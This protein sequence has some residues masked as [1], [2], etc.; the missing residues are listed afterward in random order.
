MKLK[1]SPAFE[2]FLKLIELVAATVSI[3]VSIAY[4]LMLVLGLPILTTYVCYL[5]SPWFGLCVFVFWAW[6]VG[7]TAYILQWS[8]I[9]RIINDRSEDN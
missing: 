4:L 1:R 8:E 5:L 2:F 9:Q 6:V 3:V 7:Y